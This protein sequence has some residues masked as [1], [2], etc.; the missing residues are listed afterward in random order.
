MPLY[1]QSVK[2]AS[3]LHS[4][5]LVLPLTLSEAMSG[6]AVGLILHF[7]G[8]YKEIIHVG[9][10][11]LTIGTGLYVSFS[12]TTSIG[13]IIGYQILT[14]LG[15]GL[16]FEP[17]LIALHSLV[18]QDDTSTATS[19]MGFVRNI[20]TSVSI[21][22]GGVVFQNSMD[23][24]V[25]YLLSE[26]VSSNITNLLDGGAAAANV[27]IVQT[28]ADPTQQLLVKEAF[29]SS[30]HNMWIMYTCLAGCTIVAGMFISRNVLSKVHVETKTGLKEKP[31]LEPVVP[32]GDARHA[33]V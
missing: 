13:Q 7:T 3:P 14:G 32:A 27:M 5:L 8:R 18:S 26:G 6:I 9:T 10:V 1:F 24:R 17:P 2:E 19:T 25:P 30:L 28:I 16:L 22:I 21:V 12:A 15:A 31:L 20:G 23:E 33:S 4:G 11:L 29:A